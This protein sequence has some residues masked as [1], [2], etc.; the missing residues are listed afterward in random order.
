[1]KATSLRQE[2]TYNQMRYILE[3]KSVAII[4]ASNKIHRVGGAITRNALESNYRGDIYLVNPHLP[5][6]FGKPV[7]TQ[8]SKIPGPVDLIEIIIPAPQ[9]PMIMEDAI[10]KEVKGAIIISAGFAEIGNQDLQDEVVR[11]AKRGGI[12]VLGPNCFGIINTEIDLDLSFTFTKA[13]NGSLAFV[14]QSGAMC[15][16]TLDWAYREELGFSKFINLGNKCDLDE[17]DALLYLE[18]DTQ[19]KII[20]MYLEGITNGRRLFHTVRRVSQNKPIIMLKAGVTEPGARAALSHTAS[21]A[22]SSRIVK[23]AFKQAGATVVEDVEELFDAA[24]ALV[25]PPVNGSKVAIASNAGGLGVMTT[26]W[27]HQMGLHVPHLTSEAVKSLQEQ[28]LPIASPL[29]PVDMTGSADYTTYQNI[30]KVLASNDSIDMIITIFVSQGLVTSDGPAR[31]VVDIL[32]RYKTPIFTYWMGGNSIFNGVRILRRA[33][34]PVYTS[35]AK[36]AKAAAT[37]LSYSR[38]LQKIKQENGQKS[39]ARA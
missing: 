11:I 25:Y 34:I 2:Q 38:S 24:Q 19:T 3:P 1:M 37:L 31:A 27:C 26:D 28:L 17:S 16:G 29:N 5:K 9:V 20:A 8:L 6:I 10:T 12:R 36:V 15:C 22:G 13:L 35:P 4:G 39:N 18:K 33:N 21:I 14:S 30:L 32:Q 23:A 7:Y